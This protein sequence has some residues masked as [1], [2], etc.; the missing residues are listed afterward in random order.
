MK[1]QDKPLLTNAAVLDAVA[2]VKESVSARN[3]AVGS[4]QDALIA[5]YKTAHDEHVALTARDVSELTGAER[6]YCSR[7]W[8]ACEAA[9]KAHADIDAE[10]APGVAAFIDKWLSTQA[11][12][13][14]KKSSGYAKLLAKIKE[15]TRKAKKVKIPKEQYAAVASAIML[16]FEALQPEE[17]G[18]DQVAVHALLDRAKQYLQAPA[19]MQ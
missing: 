2:R 13:V 17:E 19:T 10:V 9:V 15:A 6:S 1:T 16:L 14:T 7:V 12:R 3:R 18:P 4:L 8:R 11:R 5:L